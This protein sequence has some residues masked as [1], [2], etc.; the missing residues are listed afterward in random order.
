MLGHYP[1]ILVYGIE[2]AELGFGLELSPVIAGKVARVAE[3]IKQDIEQ[4][5]ET[6][7]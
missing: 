1:E 3:L 4:F 5:M 7:L 2:P 6:V